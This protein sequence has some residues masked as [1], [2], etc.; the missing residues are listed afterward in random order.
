MELQMYIILNRFYLLVKTVSIYQDSCGVIEYGK[1]YS[2]L[3]VWS[4]ITDVH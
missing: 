1:I 4:G 2:N 3:L